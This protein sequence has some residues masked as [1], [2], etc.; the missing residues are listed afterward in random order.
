MF[1]LCFPLEFVEIRFCVHPWQ[2]TSANVMW[3][4][5]FQC[6][7]AVGAKRSLEC[8]YHWLPYLQ[9]IPQCQ[10]HPPTPNPT[11]HTHTRTYVCTYI[12][13]DPPSHTPFYTCLTYSVFNWCIRMHWQAEFGLCSCNTVFFPASQ[14]ACLG[15]G[16]G[17]GVGGLTRGVVRQKVLMWGVCACVHAC[18][19]VRV[20]IK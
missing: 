11:P 8:S 9:Y 17:G 4:K 1:R 18:V 7:T 19:S 5:F 6:H 13:Y 15:G 3:Q 2:M 10:S 20:Q 12:E 14:C 16:G